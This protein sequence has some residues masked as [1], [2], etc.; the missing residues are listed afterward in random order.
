M[1]LLTWLLNLVYCVVVLLAAP[2]LL[3]R[4]LRH[5]KYRTGWSEKL[6]GKLPQRPTTHGEPRVWFHAVSVGEVLQ[7]QSLVADLRSSRPACD[8]VITTTTT[9]GHAVARDRFPDCTVAYFPLDFSWSVHTAISRIGPSAIVLVELEL[10]PNFIRLAR[11]AGVPLA[12]VNG[13]LSERSFRG[14][15]MLRPLMNRLLATFQFLAMQ[16]EIYAERIRQLGAPADRTVVTGSIKFDGL[17]SNRNN[18]RTAELRQ[19]FC[20]PP[21]HKVFVAGSTQAPEEELALDTYERLRHENTQLRLIVVPRHKERF[22]QVAQ[23]IRKRGLPMLRRSNPGRDKNVGTACQNQ[24]VMLLDTLG[25]LSACWGLADI[26][27]VG[28]SMGS[29]GGQNMI[30]PSAYGAAVTFGPNTWNFR[31]VVEM[32]LDNSAACVVANGEELTARVRVWLL[33]PESA[34]ATGQRAKQLVAAQQGATRQTV[35]LI[36]GMLP[37]GRPRCRSAA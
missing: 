11:R 19:F 24:S 17:Q 26:A 33:D 37:T 28:G 8:V 21:A 16:N 35:E 30:E 9:T 31:Q 18:H 2:V 27:F 32:L 36:C 6:L 22:E 12:L 10:W 14:Y 34:C 7:L 5:G 3:Y 29:R 13:R 20:L 1:S 4:I 15:R 23:L 25:E